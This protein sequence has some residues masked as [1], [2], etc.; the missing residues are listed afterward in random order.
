MLHMQRRV[1]LSPGEDGAESSPIVLASGGC[2]TPLVVERS[3]DML[4]Q[5]IFQAIAG[6]GAVGAEPP[7]EEVTGQ[8]VAS[9]FSRGAN[10]LGTHPG[11][12]IRHA[13]CG[14]DTAHVGGGRHQSGL[15]RTPGVPGGSQDGG[16]L[17][18]RATV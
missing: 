11:P 14:T 6:D 4:R 12:P 18:H 17:R 9:F 3:G 13:G 7:L 1:F 15:L 8:G 5:I 2:M 16:E 10:P